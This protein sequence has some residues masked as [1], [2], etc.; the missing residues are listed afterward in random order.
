MGRTSV[1]SQLVAADGVP[2]PLMLSVGRP[3]TRLEQSMNDK[4]LTDWFSQNVGKQASIKYL[5]SG[6]RDDWSVE[7]VIESFHQLAARPGNLRQHPFSIVS[8]VSD[9]SLADVAEQ[10][11]R[12]QPRPDVVVQGGG[13]P[14]PPRLQS[15]G[16]GHVKSKNG[17]G[18][19]R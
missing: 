19:R 11:H 15:L 16:Q 14:R 6:A 13:D 17:P 5:R 9:P 12:R 18:A 10:L 2:P 3:G 4:Y 7:G 1:A 8:I